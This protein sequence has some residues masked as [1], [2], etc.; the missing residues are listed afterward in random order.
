[1][2]SSDSLE[3][4]LFSLLFVLSLWAVQ[5]GDGVS[6]FWTCL[7]LR[8]TVTLASSYARRGVGEGGAIVNC[9]GEAFG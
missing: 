7:V 3:T 6:L 5:Y 2:L 4:L 8:L 1:M 9:A